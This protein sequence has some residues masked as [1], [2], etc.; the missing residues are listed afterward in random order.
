MRHTARWWR[1]LGLLSIV[2]IATA[3]CNKG[4]GPGG[5]TASVAGASTDVSGSPAA[6]ESTGHEESHRPV[7]KMETTLG[8]ITIEL[9]AER[10]PITVKNFLWYANNG[11]YQQTIF[12]QLV[13]GYVAIGGGYDQQLAERPTHIEIRNEAANGLKNKRGTISM[14]RRPNVVDSSTSQFFFNLAD[15]S[16][17]DQKGRNTAEEFGYCVF[18]KVID[19]MEVLDRMSA[20]PVT[21]SEKFGST[22]ATPIVVKSVSRVR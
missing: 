16:Q 6:Q 7:V 14:A 10:A 8:A 3:G 18:G 21:K 12:H 9:D 13:P 2:L 1:H 17:L 20:A 4:D 11:S 19:G 5:V 22:P 15:N